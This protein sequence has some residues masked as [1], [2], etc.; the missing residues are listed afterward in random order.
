VGEKQLENQ[1]GKPKIYWLAYKPPGNS[2]GVS[3]KSQY[4]D[5]GFGENKPNGASEDTMIYSRQTLSNT[6]DD[7]ENKSDVDNNRQTSF[8]RERSSEQ[9]SLSDR[10]SVVV[11]LQPDNISSSLAARSAPREG[12]SLPT[13]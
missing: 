8:S 1:R 6:Y 4:T 9:K 13:E 2:G 10:E 5:T 3:T 11:E 7:G 12:V